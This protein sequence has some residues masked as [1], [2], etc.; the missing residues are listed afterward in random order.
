MNVIYKLNIVKMVQFFF[1]T[2]ICALL[3]AFV[4]LFIKKIGLLEFWQTRVKS[5]L[6]YKL[7]TCDFCLSFWTNVFLSVVFGLVAKEVAF[8]L[9]PFAAAPITRKLL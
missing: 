2:V 1:N 7:L 4:L 6:L 9:T 8:V 5:D 3:A